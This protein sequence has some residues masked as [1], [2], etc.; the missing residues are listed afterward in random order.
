MPI[1]FVSAVV[2]HSSSG[3]EARGKSDSTDSACL[4]SDSGYSLTKVL[5]ATQEPIEPDMVVS[6]ETRVDLGRLL[7]VR[8]TQAYTDDG[9]TAMDACGQAHKVCCSAAIP[10][11]NRMAKDV[12]VS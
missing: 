6:T 8:L 3:K 5:R 11:V 2:D 12:F 7:P 4:V 1:T 9:P 10:P